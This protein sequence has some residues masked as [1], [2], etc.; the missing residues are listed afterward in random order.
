MLTPSSNFAGPKRPKLTL[1]S[2]VRQ[3]SA[4]VVKQALSSLHCAG[5][6][7]V[8]DLDP[9]TPAAPST[10]ASEMP[11]ASAEE[12]M[13][14]CIT[15]HAKRLKPILRCVFLC[16]DVP[17]NVSDAGE[18]WHVQCAS[19]TFAVHHAT[20]LQQRAVQKACLLRG[21]LPVITLPKLSLEPWK[22]RCA[23]N[24]FALLKDVQAR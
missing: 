14:P 22:I 10:L 9:A 16:Q 17:C 8:P 12:G 6:P 21:P 11:M 24:L 23:H 2:A 3:K 4:T 15:C 5:A 18:G 1:L 20:R 7:E 13:C 19:V